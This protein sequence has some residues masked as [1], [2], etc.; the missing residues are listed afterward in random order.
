MTDTRHVSFE[1]FQTSVLN[2]SFK[3]LRNPERTARDTDWTA[4]VP[5]AGGRLRSRRLDLAGLAFAVSGR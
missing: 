5:A 4:T 2:D 3:T 1:M